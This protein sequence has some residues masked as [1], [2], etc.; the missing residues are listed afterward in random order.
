MNRLVRLIVELSLV[1]R[2]QCDSEAPLLPLVGSLTALQS[3]V[4]HC[5][6]PRTAIFIYQF[7][8][9]PAIK[10]EI[11]SSSLSLETRAAIEFT[12]ADSTSTLAR[13]LTYPEQK[14]LVH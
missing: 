12:L 14:L 9:L 2:R 8:S 10:Q 4:L 1:C 7:L 5:F 6:D 13:R 11:L 3:F